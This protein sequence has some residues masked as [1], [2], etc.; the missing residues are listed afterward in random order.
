[1]AAIRETLTLQDQFT[2]TLQR[3]AQRLQEAA[4]AGNTN[5]KAV[6]GLARETRAYTNILN[7]QSAA[8]RATERQ[9]R[10]ETAAINKQTAMT[11]AAEQQIKSETS[12]INQQTAALKQQTTALKLQEQQQRLDN[13]AKKQATGELSKMTVAIKNLA[14]AYL[15]V[16]GVQKLLNVSDQMSQIS[17]RLS[18]VAE[19][20]NEVNGTMVTTSALSQ[21][22]MQAANNS[23]GSYMDMASFVSKLG[24]LATGAFDNTDELVL[25]SEQIQKQMKLSGTSAAEASGAML[26]LTQAMSSGVLRGEELNSVMEQTP[27]IAQTIAQYLGMSTGEMKNLAAEGGITAEVVKNAMLSAVDETDKKFKS[28]PATWSDV[29]ALMANTMLET[30]QPALNGISKMAQ[31]SADNVDTLIPILYGAAAALG[32]YAAAMG[33]SAA[34]AWAAKIANDGLKA[35]LLSNPIGW[36]ALLIGVVVY[37]IYQWVQSVGGLKVAWL[38]ATNEILTNADL[39]KIGFLSVWYSIQDGAANMKANVLMTAQGMVNG[40]ISGIN[41]MI[42]KINSIFGTSYSTMSEW[43]GG[44]VAQIQATMQ[45]AEHANTL[46]ELSVVARKA[47]MER[48]IEIAYAKRETEQGTQE[49]AFNVGSIPT[50]SEM[51]AAAAQTADNTGKTAKAASSIAKSVDKSK[52]DIK[53]LVDIATRRFINNVNVNSAAPVINMS[54]NATDSTPEGRKKLADTLRDILIE[55]R[56]SGST[57][58]VGRY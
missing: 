21:Q 36:I 23:R 38:I 17:G 52:E 22:I 50:Y 16:Q 45:A 24:T 15:S 6:N 30:L 8:S 40:V 34:A 35:T 43:Q 25:F 31:W 37:Y 33:V 27:M 51:G 55:Q 32:V 58:T 1:M 13:Q 29:G 19:S 18:L 48:R 14:A 2:P 54:V 53:S 12:A 20:F 49:T 3:Y 44:T 7:A 10:A 57:V 41:Q 42:N 46:S 39:L 28:I 4:N 9:A 47:Q 56:S 5:S 26:Q 11:K